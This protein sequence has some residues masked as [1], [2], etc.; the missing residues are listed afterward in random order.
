[1]PE[2]VF[3]Q[4]HRWGAAFPCS[5]STALVDLQ[6]ALALELPPEEVNQIKCDRS[7]LHTG[8]GLGICGDFLHLPGTVE[9]AVLSASSLASA[10]IR[11]D[12]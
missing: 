7:V 4:G 11:S 9:G 2:P 10:I 3:K 1:V 5:S 12:N 6:R 8:L